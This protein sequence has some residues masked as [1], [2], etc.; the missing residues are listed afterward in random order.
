MSKL[1]LWLLGPIFEGLSLKEGHLLTT[2]GGAEATQG[3]KT[4]T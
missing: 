3:H 2:L 4:L 1:R